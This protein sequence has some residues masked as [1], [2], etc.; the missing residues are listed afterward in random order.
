[1][2]YCPL[3][4]YVKKEPKAEISYLYA[5]PIILPAHVMKVS[6]VLLC[7]QAVANAIDGHERAAVIRK[8]ESIQ[9]QC[10][11]VHRQAVEIATCA[12][13]VHM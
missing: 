4:Q 12:N 13:A 3:L 5:P 6:E 9:I 10:L 11:A 2:T 1:M 8:N 7:E